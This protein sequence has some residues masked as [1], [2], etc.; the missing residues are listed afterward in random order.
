MK[1]T[2]LVSFFPTTVIS[3]KKTV[4]QNR[5]AEENN[6]LM[7]EFINNGS[8]PNKVVTDPY[9]RALIDFLINDGKDRKGCYQHMSRSG[10]ATTEEDKF[11]DLIWK[12]TDLIDEIRKWCV[13]RTG[14]SSSFVT[15]SHD[16][17]DG[18]REKINSISLFF[19]HPRNP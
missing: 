17:W 16:I 14:K 4:F 11:H 18:K 19:I 9:F 5:I 6:L 1:S 7:Y 10:H 15:I 2:Y 13:D 3:Q 12:I 8:R